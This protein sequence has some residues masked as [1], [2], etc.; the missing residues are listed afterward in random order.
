M[1]FPSLL[2]RTFVTE[3][4][5]YAQQEDHHMQQQDAHDSLTLKF[6]RLYLAIPIV[7]F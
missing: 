4:A 7:S 1:G 6:I 3:I 2:S 5:I